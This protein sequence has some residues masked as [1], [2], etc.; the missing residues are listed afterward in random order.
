MIPFS[1]SRTTGESLREYG[2]GIAGGLMFSM[3]LLFTMEM[4]WSGFNMHPW[5]IV[6]FAATT[7]ALLLLYNRFAGLRRDASLR[8]VAIDSVEEMGIGLVLSAA[9]LALLGRIGWDQHPSE[10][11]GKVVMEAM[12]VA[13]GVSVGTAQLGAPDDGDGGADGDESDDDPDAY[14]PQLAIGLCAGVLFAT[15]IAPTE[16]VVVLATENGPLRLLGI[17]AVSLGLCALIFYFADFRSAGRYVARG[18]WIITL[19]GIVSSYAVSLFASGVL[20]WFFGRFDAAPFS[21]CVGLTVPKPDKKR[22]RVDGFWHQSHLG[23]RDLRLACRRCPTDGCRPRALANPHRPTRNHRW[24]RHHPRH[25]EKRRRSSRRKRRSP[26][27]TRHRS[28]PPRSHI[29]DRLHPARRHP[30]RHRVVPS[31]RRTRHARIHRRRLQHAV[32]NKERRSPKRLLMGR[33]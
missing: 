5:R 20:L 11:M 18:S 32:S 24:P 26:R 9:V 30:P 2:R 15:N 31:Y 6:G 3:P 12:T 22:P 33:Q 4:W 8:E 25:G 7:F 21:H 27:H 23:R 16:E 10:I 14:L 1:H 19:R 13:I 17:A 28:G 29:Y